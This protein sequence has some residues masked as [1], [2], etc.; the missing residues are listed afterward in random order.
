MAS[1]GSFRMKGKPAFNK[2]IVTLVGVGIILAGAVAANLLLGD[3]ARGGTLGGASEPEGGAVS[4]SA[5]ATGFFESFRTQRDTTREKEIAY[6][7][8]IIAAGAD[9]ETMAEAQQQ[10]LAI[11]DSMEKEMTVE[12]LLRAKGFT[13][14]AVTLHTGSVNVIVKAEQ[15]SD[16]QVAQ[17][18]DIVI[19]E[20]GESA[21]NIKLTTSQ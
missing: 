15:L 9:E 19:R 20:T 11:V 21:E 8:T 2:K 10:K 14:A 5:G 7:D 16:E 4:A 6:I 17:V 3:K 18:L 12:S 1:K 13:D